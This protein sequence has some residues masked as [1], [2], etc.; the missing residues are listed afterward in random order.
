MIENERER[1]M[2]EYIDQT[3]KKHR[4]SLHMDE[5]AMLD[6][7]F[8]WSHDVILPQIPGKIKTKS[9]CSN[10]AWHNFERYCWT[11]Y[12]I[13]ECTI[14]GYSPE[15]DAGKEYYQPCHAEFKAWEAK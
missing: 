9:P 5:I 10:P 2:I 7:M 12:Y 15:L 14:C 11:T 8:A 6:G 1:C 13:R 4:E 3:G